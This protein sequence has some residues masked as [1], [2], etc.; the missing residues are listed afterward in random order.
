MKKNNLIIIAIS[1]ILLLDLSSCSEDVLIEKPLDFFSPENAFVNKEGFDAALVGLYVTARNEMA[2]GDNKYEVIMSECTDVATNAAASVLA[3][4]SVWQVMN[5]TTNYTEFYWY[6]AYQMIG[7]ANTII[8]RAENPDISW[9]SADDKNEVLAQARFFRGYVYSVLVNLYGGVPIIKE[10]VT[11]PRYDYTRETRQKVLEFIVEDLEFASLWLPETTP[12][13]GKIVK[14]TADHYLSETYLGLQEYTKAIESATRVIN[15]GHYKLMT[16]RFGDLSRPGDVYSDLFW[17]HQINRSSG[18]LETIWAIQ[19]EYG[20]TGGIPSD[21]GNGQLRRWGPAYYSIKDPDNKIGLVLC[22]SLGRPNGWTTPTNY[23]RY[24][25]WR[26]DWDNDMRNSKYNIRRDY[27]FNTG[28]YFGQKV[29]MENGFWKGTNIKVESIDTMRYMYPWFR[30]IEGFPSGGA[31]SGM[32]YN[33]FIKVRLSETYLLR[34]EA[35]FLAGE[36]QKAADDINDIRNRANATPVDPEDVDLDYILDE[37]ARELIVEERRLRT[38]IRM[39]KLVERVKKHNF[40]EADYI[41]DYHK[42]WP[43]PQ[44]VIDANIDA[45]IEQN[46]GY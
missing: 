5:P 28:N 1:L 10:E 34:A 26:S 30:K 41:Q 23:S 22:D 40:R 33:E 29:E 11:T 9:D 13:D 31:A 18:N 12:E 46:P 6:W 27:Y 19:V 3:V 38:L 16:E 25:I 39:G 20:V 36:S 44:S 43:I 15:S 17:T 8:T 37:R 32:S 7:R 4:T 2:S 24:D 14:A 35:Y 45:V 42:L 21:G